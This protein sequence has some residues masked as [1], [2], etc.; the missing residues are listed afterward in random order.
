MLSRVSLAIAVLLLVGFLYV[1]SQ[2][3]TYR[4]ERSLATTAAPEVVYATVEDL[5]QFSRWSPWDGRDPNLQRTFSGPERGPGARVSWQG[6]VEVGSGTMSITAAS[7]PTALRYLMVLER[8]WRTTIEND[9]R[10]ERAANGAGGATVTWVISG[11]LGF[12][13]KLFT[14]FDDRDGRVGKDLETGLA[15]LKAL[16]ESAPATSARQ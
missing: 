1:V 7:P 6:N 9:F 2:P 5:R 15:K 12:W 4:I 16:A 11:K 10:L 8:P 14:L 13:A 3:D